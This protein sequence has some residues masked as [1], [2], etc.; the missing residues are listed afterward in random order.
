MK[1]KN[2]L[3]FSVLFLCLSVFSPGVRDGIR[4]GRFP[5]MNT[6]WMPTKP[7]GYTNPKAWTVKCWNFENG[8]RVA[9]H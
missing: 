1:T 2:F 3:L 7:S 5:I 8:W 6:M 9:R 4:S